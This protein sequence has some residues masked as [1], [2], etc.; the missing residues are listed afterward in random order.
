MFPARV[1]ALETSEAP[2]GGAG[3]EIPAMRQVLEANLKPLVEGLV[4]KFKQISGLKELFEAPRGGAGIEIC[5]TS[6][7]SSR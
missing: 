2:R 7:L 1:A 3:I 5:C 4:L 6:Y